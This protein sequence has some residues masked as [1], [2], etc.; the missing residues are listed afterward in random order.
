MGI[1]SN[2]FGSKKSC[3]IDDYMKNNKVPVN[4]T[5]LYYKFP[6]KREPLEG[7]MKEYYS[8][9]DFIKDFPQFEYLEFNL[10]DSKHIRITSGFFFF[11]RGYFYNEKTIKKCL[12]KKIGFY[13]NEKPPFKPDPDMMEILLPNKEHFDTKFTGTPCF[14]IELGSD[15]QVN[16]TSLGHRGVVDARTNSFANRFSTLSIGS[17]DNIP[18]V[19][20][21]KIP[22]VCVDGHNYEKFTPE[23]MD[24]H[25]VPLFAEIHYGQIIDY[26]QYGSYRG[27]PFLE[28]LLRKENIEVNF[29]KYHEIDIDNYLDGFTKQSRKKKLEKIM[30]INNEI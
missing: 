30:R 18:I 15:L 5:K 21:D 16:F 17:V 4:F 2:I 19:F 3:T 29:L 8:F 10:K 28:R 14:L 26:E 23:P 7:Q 27:I 9:D 13:M 6:E 1:L 25:D 24:E 20:D 11:Y 12:S 22:L